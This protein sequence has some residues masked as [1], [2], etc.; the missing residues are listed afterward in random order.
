MADTS[1]TISSTM[2]TARVTT[3]V[4][5]DTT[6]SM[7]NVQRNGLANT[8]AIPIAS[9]ATVCVLAVCITIAIIV[10]FKWR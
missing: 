8:L 7:R 1:T 4:S 6:E 9:L 10:I 3:T 2:N 5:S